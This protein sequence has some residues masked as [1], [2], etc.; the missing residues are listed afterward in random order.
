MNACRQRK[1]PFWGQRTEIDTL[2]RLSSPSFISFISCTERFF[3]RDVRFCSSKSVPWHHR[4]NAADT[5]SRVGCR[6][7]GKW[8][9]APV[10][11]SNIWVRSQDT[12]RRVLWLWLLRAAIPAWPVAPWLKLSN[13]SGGHAPSS[14]GWPEREFG[15]RG[16]TLVLLS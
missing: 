7:G 8:C 2:T 5:I 16:G 15:D 11:A 6:E 9:S 10:L 14:A 4:L 3:Y 12:C 1:F 13:M